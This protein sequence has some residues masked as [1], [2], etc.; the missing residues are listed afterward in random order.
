MSVKKVIFPIDLAGSSHRIASQVRSIVDNLDAELHLVI[1]VDI[2]KGYD[3]FFIPHRSLDLMEMED[4]ALAKRDLEEFAEK[5]FQDVPRVKRVVLHGKPVEQIRKY[6]VSEEA[7]MVIVAAHHLP[8]LERTIFGDM[9]GKIVRTSPVP[10]TAINP[11]DLEKIDIPVS[12]AE[13]LMR[14][15]LH[16]P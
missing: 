14:D 15:R 13:P 9:A 2:F 3:T 8:F 11:F 6:V 7:D 10:V 4:M 12:V 16:A 1:A 5:Y